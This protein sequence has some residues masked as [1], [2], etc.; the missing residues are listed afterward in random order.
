LAIC[1]AVLPKHV[2]HGFRS[3]LRSA[4]IAAQVA[5]SFVLLVGAGLFLRTLGNLI[6]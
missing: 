3:S 5:M 4:L 6:A 2:W 1:A